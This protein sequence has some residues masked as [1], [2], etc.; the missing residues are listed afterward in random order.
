MAQKP[1]RPPLTGALAK[2]SELSTKQFSDLFG[3]FL[4]QVGVVGFT[5]AAAAL[6]GSPAGVAILAGAF[7]TWGLHELRERGAAEETERKKRSDARKAERL[8]RKIDAVSGDAA[9]ALDLLLELVDS[10]KEHL[11]RGDFNES[12]RTLEAFMKKRF[13]DIDS[14]LADGFANVLR[15]VAVLDE[16][17]DKVLDKVG[18]PEPDDA[19]AFTLDDY[20]EDVTAQSRQLLLERFRIGDRSMNSEVEQ[21][22]LAQI[23]VELNVRRRSAEDEDRDGLKAR[24]DAAVARGFGRQPGSVF[25]NPLLTKRSFQALVIDGVPPFLSVP[26]QSGPISV[27]AIAD[28][29]LNGILLVD[30]NH[31]PKEVLRAADENDELVLVVESDGWPDPTGGG[32]PEVAA[33]LHK[34]WPNARVFAHLRNPS[35]SL[36]HLIALDPELHNLPG[37]YVVRG[38]PG[39][40]KT[41]VLRHTALSTALRLQR[42]VGVG[43]V[44]VF[45]SLPTWARRR[46]SLENLLRENH[47]ALASDE[48]QNQLLAPPGEDLLL[49]FDGLDEVRGLDARL[50]I[51]GRLR[52]AASQWPAARMVV[53]T[54]KVGYKPFAPNDFADVDLLPLDRDRQRE[55]LRGWLDS[56]SHAH[57]TAKLTQRIVRDLDEGGPAFHELREVPLLLTF[58]A[59]L[60]EEAADNEN[61]QLARTRTAV[62]TGI[63]EH[64]MQGLHRRERRAMQ[65]PEGSRYALR[66]LAE[67]CTREDGDDPPR[68]KLSSA[69]TA[70]WRSDEMEDVREY[71]C[72]DDKPPR[73]DVTGFLKELA[74]VTG[75]LGGEARDNAPWSFWHRTLRE[76]LVAQRFAEDVKTPKGRNR[77][78]ALACDLAGK[79]AQWAEPFALFVGLTGSGERDDWLLE[80]AEQNHALALR[81]LASVEG[82]A[83]TTIEKVLRLEGLDAEERCR[84]YG[85]L[86]ERLGGKVEI[87]PTAAALLGRLAAGTDDCMDLWHIARALDALEREERGAA[88]AV[89]RAR[90][91]LFEHEKFGDTVDADALEVPRHP[92]HDFWRTVEAGTKFVMGSPEKEKGRYDDE[93]PAHEVRIETGYQIGAVPVTNALW[94]RFRREFD[95][96]G[97]SGGPDAPVTEVSWYEAAMFCTWIGARLPSEAEWECACRAGT[98]TRFWSGDSDEDLARVGWFYGNSEGKIHPVARK[99]HEQKLGL[100]DM[101]GNVDEWC[102]DEWH[103][104]YEGAPADGSAWEKGGFGYRVRRGGSFGYSAGYARSAIRDGWHPEDRGDSL[105]FRPARSLP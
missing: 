100:F 102:Q 22:L 70:I 36:E 46:G 6:Y 67:R 21:R 68:S 16:K 30:P 61:F 84:Q 59:M 23:Y 80:L 37:R 35:I 44:P 2:L 4:D 42:S 77:L 58:V 24:F 45:V 105:G 28:H 31:D 79:E 65:P 8:K 83:D 104:D 93:G 97:A 87:V 82:V 63:L 89:K 60:Y 18:R 94:A 7:A 50:W 98:K 81:T 38:H 25:W 47:P 15:G 56:G 74:E 33:D 75:I 20:L 32:W 5:A 40:G 1:A 66:H 72:T 101:H 12:K 29:T 41:T 34:R 78:L 14:N 71:W 11:T 103:D 3:K 54:R 26:V 96:V 48:L 57:S 85:E 51:A 92:E 52:D 49:L 27:A 69:L 43:P 39:T 55:L 9:S 90:A 88:D 99:P 10:E 17:L 73:P 19:S 64:L 76:A 95:A 91:R 53:A 86:R 13:D 62:Y